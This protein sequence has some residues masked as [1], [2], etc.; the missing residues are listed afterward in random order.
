MRPPGEVRTALLGAVEALA[1]GGGAVNFRQAAAYAQV[2]AAVA[3]RTLENMA[4]AGVVVKVGHDKPADST[5]WH[6]MYAP[7]PAA[8]VD[9]DTPQPW[10][11]IERLAAVMKTFP[12]AD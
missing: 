2:G 9:D 11:G 5:H 8:D 10:G 4:R 3:Q 7:L 12:R 6:A 1:S